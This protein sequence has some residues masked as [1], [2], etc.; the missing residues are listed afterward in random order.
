M[1][2]HIIIGAVFRAL[3]AFPSGWRQPGAHRRPANDARVLRSFARAAEAAALDF[4]YLGDWLAT[5]AE[6]EHTEPDLLARLEPLAAAGYLAAATKKIG[7]VATANTTFSDAYALARSS[8][9]LDRLSGGRLGLNLTAGGDDASLANFGSRT[10]LG[11]AARYD[12][13]EEFLDALRLLWDS[14]E[15]DAFVADTR[16]GRLVDETRMHPADYDGEHVRVA[17][18][19]NALRPV[20]GQIPVLH[21]G[22]SQRSR[23]LLAAHGDLAIAAFCDPVDAA[24][25]RSELHRLARGF[26][27]HPDHLRLL[28]PVLPIVAETV[29]AARARFDALVATV[30]LDDEFGP[31]AQPPERDEPRLPGRGIRTLSAAVGVSLGR[32]PLDAVIPARTAA[33]FHD[34]GQRLVEAARTHTGRVPDGD[35]ALT[36]RHLLIEHL[37]PA[38]IVVGDGARVADHLESW[39]TAG[40]VDGFTVLSAYLPAPFTAFVTSVVPELRRRG[41][42]RDEY[43][44]STLRD[45]L[46]LGH[47]V[48]VYGAPHEPNETEKRRSA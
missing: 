23:R 2:S 12:R 19:L 6:F 9:S 45:H 41:L 27:R 14:W 48:N 37:S 31:G 10:P 30:P 7:I 40:A 17:G 32:Q 15:D 1:S 24:A 44:G 13:A 33:R 38:S 16:S 22:T 28:T 35:P 42:F 25:Y 21:A 26:G 46:A 36:Y 29:D 39:F 47:P 34:R 20:Q 8:A 5:G 3:G 18:A 4:V 43:E 11:A